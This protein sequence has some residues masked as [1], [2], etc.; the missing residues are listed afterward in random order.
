MSL[1]KGFFTCLYIMSCGLC[2]Y[3]VYIHEITP[4][5]NK[6][7]VAL[8]N[9]EFYFIYFGQRVFEVAKNAKRQKC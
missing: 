3:I 9:K 5:P 7:A 2:I 1:K 8:S 6:F 4:S